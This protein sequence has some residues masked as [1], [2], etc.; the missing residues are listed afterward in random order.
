MTQDH[1]TQ[2]DHDNEQ[3]SKRTLANRQNA[4]KS[5]GPRTAAGKHRVSMN[6]FKHGLSGQNLCL[7]SDDSVPYFDLALRFIE[8]LRPVGVR[9]EQLAQKIIDG[10]WRLNRAAAIENNLLNNDTVIEAHFL[11]SDDERSVAVAGQANAWRADCAGPRA[12]ESLGRHEGRIART[13][14]KMTAEFD[15]LQAR[16]LKRNKDVDSF[17][18]HESRAWQFLS[19]ALNHYRA[20]EKEKESAQ[21]E[22]ETEE[23]EEVEMKKSPETPQTAPNTATSGM[24]LNWQSSPAPALYPTRSMTR[25]QVLRRFAASIGQPLPVF[26]GDEDDSSPSDL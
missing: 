24:A 21:A 25:N 18:Q 3:P 8:D 7:Q 22:I 2:T 1:I 5:T 26:T 19:N 12:L 6:A 17:V 15:A 11:T 20:M 13:Q 14:F 16:R 23:I 9:E 10:N 4:Q